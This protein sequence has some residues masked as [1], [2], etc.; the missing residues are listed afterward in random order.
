MKTNLDAIKEF[1][2][3]VNVPIFTNDNIDVDYLRLPRDLTVLPTQ[4]ISKYLNA[5]VQQKMY[6]RTL[7][8]QARAIYREAKS[9][10]DKE[11]CRVFASAPPKMSVT[12]KELRVFQD[13]Q[14]EESRRYM[15]QSL[16]KYDFLKDILE[17]YGTIIGHYRIS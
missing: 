7:V 17:S 8:S 2:V 9:D 5:I 10:F 3:E 15:E 1:L 13:T 16:E 12:E 14:A 6:V 11:K 4:E